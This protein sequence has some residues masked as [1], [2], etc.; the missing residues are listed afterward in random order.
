[1]SHMRRTTE[2]FSLA[3]LP[4]ARETDPMTSPVQ[5]PARTG[6][7]ASPDSKRGPR[8]WLGQCLGWV[9]QTRGVDTPAR[10]VTLA[11]TAPRTPSR[12]TVAAPVEPL[13][14]SIGQSVLARA[15]E[16]IALTGELSPELVALLLH[17]RSPKTESARDLVA[18]PVERAF[19]SILADEVLQRMPAHLCRPFVA[20]GQQAA[21][22]LAQAEPARRE[23]W[24]RALCAELLLEYPHPW[25]P[26]TPI[27]D[28][29][30]ATSA[31][32]EQ[33]YASLDAFW[34]QPLTDGFQATASMTILRAMYMAA[35]H[36]GISAQVLPF[37]SKA[38]SFYVH[39]L[40]TQTG[41]A[42]AVTSAE[43][44]R[45]A[46]AGI[47]E[48]GAPS[49][50]DA[51]WM[52]LS[53]RASHK[54]KPNLDNSHVRQALQY[55]NA[56]GVGISGSTN[57]FLFA[58]AHYQQQGVPGL[59]ALALTTSIAAMLC[60]SG[61][62]SLHECFAAAQQLVRPM[63]TQLGSLRTYHPGHARQTFVAL[64]DPQQQTNLLRR[65]LKR[66]THFLQT[67]ELGDA[68]Q[69]TVDSLHD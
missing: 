6:A 26:K 49:P 2:S 16:S 53:I 21:L 1:M 18:S 66:L 41:R 61:G 3:Q 27:V 30:C 29:L 46:G 4:V 67:A 58:A 44:Q 62:H 59:D 9:K 33:K 38:S 69:A 63:D 14:E 5:R 17:R 60:Y 12:P 35:E 37:V 64:A 43:P 13:P 50:I 31:S 32:S 25:S 22:T 68:K 55:G 47:T 40:L 52:P 36:L 34:R 42:R 51:S 11:G 24:M 19:D 65:S 57:L 56:Y 39:H 28:I 8:K 23:K 10:R 54:H 48:F 45:Q 15:Q 7:L 20:L